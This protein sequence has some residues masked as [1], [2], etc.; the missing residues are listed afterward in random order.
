MKANRLGDVVYTDKYFPAE[1]K[2]E[3]YL[4]VQP[5]RLYRKV[6]IPFRF[7]QVVGK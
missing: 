3:Y 4:R 5:I 1:K 2:K 7:S 6:R